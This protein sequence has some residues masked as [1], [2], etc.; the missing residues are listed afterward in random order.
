[1]KDK[2]VEK[3][4][5]IVAMS[6]LLFLFGIALSLFGES[7]GFFKKVG[8]LDFLFG[9]AWYP[10]S[11]PPSYGILPLIAGSF[12]VTLGAIL[13]SLPIGIGS[14]IYLA[15]IA[16]ER[17]RKILKPLLEILASVPSVIYGL[18]GML[19]IS[20]LTMKIFKIPVGLNL[21]TASLLLGV[22]SIPTITTIAEDAIVSVDKTLKEGAYA[23]GATKWETITG[24]ILPAAKSGIFTA[25]MLGVGRSIGET[26][27]VLMVAGGAAVI[28]KSIFSPVRPMTATIAS[29]MG[30]APFGT[31]HYHALFAI[32]AVLFVFT[33]FLNILAEYMKNRGGKSAH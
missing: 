33:L 22:M 2:N 10:T 11:A 30:E 23:L 1:M 12:F 13:I 4:F 20:P 31:I 14:A 26:M 18:F 28:P 19:V 24:I 5:F 27:T 21:F 7:I 8:V 9:K 6:S 15:E 3:I 32:A 29:E 25:I 17:K 16:S